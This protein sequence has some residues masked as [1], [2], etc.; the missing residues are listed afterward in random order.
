MAKTKVSLPKSV[1][2]VKIPKSIRKVGKDVLSHP[3]ARVIIAEALVHAAAGLLRN[4]ARAGSTVRN[5][6][7]HPIESAESVRSSGADAA[8][9]V[10]TAASGTASRIA[11]A[12]E[13]LLEYIQGEAPEVPDHDKRRKRKSKDRKRKAKKRDF[14]RSM[15]ARTTH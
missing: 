13:G 2:G 9:A 15:E 12:I 11:R 3:M 7:E 4:Q 8:A 6:L 1:A 14:G 10:G 5:I